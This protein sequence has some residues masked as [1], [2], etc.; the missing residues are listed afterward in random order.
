MNEFSF[1][2]KRA[3]D[4]GVF[5]SA[6]N[7]IY[8]ILSLL[9]FVHFFLYLFIYTFISLFIYLFMHLFLYLISFIPLSFMRLCIYHNDELNIF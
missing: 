2:V 5:F 1:M 3:K 9:L 8:I 7:S 6:T 4:D